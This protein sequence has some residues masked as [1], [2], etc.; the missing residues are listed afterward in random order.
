MH[1]DLS[2]N[3]VLLDSCGTP[4]IADFGVSRASVGNGLPGSGGGGVRPTPLG[5]FTNGAGTPIYL[6]PQMHTRHYGIQGGTLTFGCVLTLI[7]GDMWE[8]AVLLSELL[9]GTIPEVTLPKSFA[10][11]GEFMKLQR[12]PLPS[13]EIAGSFLPTNKTSPHK[14]RKLTGFVKTLET[15]PLRSAS[16]MK[17]V[18]RACIDLFSVAVESC[19]SILEI[20]RPSFPANEKIL[21]TCAEIVFT[22]ARP[23]RTTTNPT[24]STST[25]VPPL[26]SPS[27]QH[28]SSTTTEPA[29]GTDNDV[30][31]HITACLA[32][33]VASFPDHSSSS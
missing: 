33:I 23:T 9:Q 15:C 3:N 12:S 32:G 1:R 19:L 14:T 6:P 29:G 2:S 13:P 24:T 5:T 4:K 22:T 28:P 25:T 27:R 11:M 17:N 10:K 18:H 26:R 20:N 7:P 30:T 21:I 31:G 8:F 16:A